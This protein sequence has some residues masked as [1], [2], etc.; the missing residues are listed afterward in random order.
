MRIESSELG[1]YRKITLRMLII[2]T[3]VA[4]ISI[5]HP[6]SGQDETALGDVA[7]QSRDHS[8]KKGEPQSGAATT[9]NQWASRIQ[10]Q[11][12]ETGTI[13]DGFGRYIGPGYQVWVPAPFSIIGR[14]DAGTLLGSSEVAGLTTKVFAGVPIHIPKRLKDVEF[15]SWASQFWRPYGTLTCSHQK[16]GALYRDCSVSVTLLG[17]QGFG[18]ARF[19]ENGDEFVP[20]VC[21]ATREELETVDLSHTHSRQEQIAMAERAGRNHE[22]QERVAVSGMVC[23]TVLDSVRIRQ[24]TEPAST[25]GKSVKTTDA[26]TSSEA[27]PEPVPN[28][29]QI[30]RES[31]ARVQN[32]KVRL[33][34]Q[35]EDSAGMAPD[36]FRLYQD[37]FCTQQECW[38]ESFFLPESARRVKGGGSDNAYVVTRGDL[39]QAIFYFGTTGVEFDYTEFGGAQDVARQWIHAGV[40]IK[41][42]PVRVTHTI[43]GRSVL[44]VRSRLLA[45]MNPWT[46]EQAI[47]TTDGFRMRIGCILPEDQ[48]IDHESTCS[49]VFESWQAHR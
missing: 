12:D 40:D 46:E 2:S 6:V 35:E 14:N 36:G 20:V 21:F 38:Q 15:S 4:L 48:F 19:V 37:Q 49:D 25:I 16:P 43:D 3:A 33:S 11:Q 9:T 8:T 34:V 18:S 26:L 7:R 44:L 30:A 41:T 29:A 32:A 24:A 39:T 1:Q 22:R 42:Q 10:Q 28:L 23:N 5:A 27:H 17:F 31:K 47:I 45:N 13:P